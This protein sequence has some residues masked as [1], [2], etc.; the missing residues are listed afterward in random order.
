MLELILMAF[1]VAAVAKLADY[2]ERSALNWGLI[3]LGICVASL[4]LVPL[5][6]GR[7]LLGMV[8]AIVA[9]MVMKFKE[10]G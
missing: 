8:L 9:M 5:P 7:V 10:E 4:F 2:E 1:A 3:A 6:F